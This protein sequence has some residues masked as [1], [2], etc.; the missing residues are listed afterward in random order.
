MRRGHALAVL[1][2]LAAA[3]PA[4]APA[5][6]LAQPAAA[7]R[8]DSFLDRFGIT[9]VGGEF[10]VVKPSQIENTEVLGVK[11][12]YGALS[13]EWRLVFGLSYWRSRYTDAVVRRFEDSLRVA[14]DDPTGDATVR[15]GTVR[16][17]L[18]GLTA[19]ARWSPWHARRLR[20]YLGGGI[21]GYALDAEGRGISGTFVEQALDQITIGLAAVA[22]GE[23]VLLPNFSVGLH[24]RYDVL[25][26][27]RF[28]SLRAGASYLL[29][30]DSGT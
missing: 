25:S 17:S 27:T 24:A 10:G 26:G 28:G 19:D 20:P 22:G 14:L 29:R 3:V 12:D 7:P 2:L 8:D 16:A 15:I 4:A 30:P 6:A 23:L 13:R 11:A 9:S 21:G 1:V 18:I 5:R